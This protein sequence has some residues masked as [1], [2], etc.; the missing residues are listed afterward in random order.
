MGILC[1]YRKKKDTYLIDCD[2]NNP[3]ELICAGL[4]YEKYISCINH[5]ALL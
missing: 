5:A 2:K 4:C 3:V 1:I